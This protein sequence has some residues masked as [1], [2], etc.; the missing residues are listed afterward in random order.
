M[1]NAFK[2]ALLTA[3]KN[4]I[5]DKLLPAQVYTAFLNCICDAVEKPPV[6]WFDV[7]DE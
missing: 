3:K 1:K 5:E 2:E 4:L 7:T 6:D